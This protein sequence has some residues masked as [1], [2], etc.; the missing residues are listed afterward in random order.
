L[1]QNFVKK[2]ADKCITGVLQ[3]NLKEARFLGGGGDRGTIRCHQ[4]KSIAPDNS[5]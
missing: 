3:F 5:F 2:T 1:N 4:P